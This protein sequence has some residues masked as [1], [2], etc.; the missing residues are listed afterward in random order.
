M[1]T[2]THNSV[3]AVV[4]PDG[5]WVEELRSDGQP[6]LFPKT[7][8][9]S[10]SGERKT[11]GGMHVCLP[12]FGPGGDSGLAQHG[13]GRTAEWDIVSQSDNSVLLRL[14]N[15]PLDPVA[16]SG[17]EATLQYTLDMQQ[18]VST[19]RI[20]NTG[21]EAQRSAPGF[22][23]YFYIDELETAV[24]VNNKLYELSELAGTEFI[25][26]ESITLKTSGRSLV[27][28]QENLSTWALW[29][30]GLA[31]YACV[32]PTYGGYRFLEP[33]THDEHLAPGA[34]KSFSCTI[35]W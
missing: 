4:N 3:Y 30:D 20:K 9:T 19:L 23:P 26:T 2:L 18:L 33:P 29:T 6:I 25:T 27:I 17:L 16:Y 7:E 32:E 22:H 34:E 14:Q 35:S 28:T 31:N 12:N 1:I 15:P 8:L 21:R 11:R 5:A 24:L 10:E 13:F